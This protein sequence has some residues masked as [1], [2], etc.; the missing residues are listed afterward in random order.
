MNS[1]QK[2]GLVK[3]IAILLALS[4]TFIITIWLILSC[5]PS[6]LKGG[7]NFAAKTIDMECDFFQHTEE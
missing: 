6:H 3:F 4:V 1:E 5:N 2:I 7:V